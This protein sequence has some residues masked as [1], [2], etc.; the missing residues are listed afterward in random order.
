MASI[1]AAIA[2]DES[3]TGRVVEIKD[4]FAVGPI[5]DI[6]ETEGYQARRDWWKDVLTHSPY[7]DQIAIVDDKLTVNQLINALDHDENEF[8]WIW[9]GQNTHDVCGYYWLM[10]Q[11]KPY[12]GRLQVLYLNNLPFLNEKGQLFY[13]THLSEIQPKEFLKAK[14]LARPITLSEFELDPDEWK[15]LCQEN[16][17]VRFLEGGKKLVSMPI[18]FYDKEILSLLTKNAQKLPSALAHILSKMKVKTGDAFI[19]FRLKAIAEMGKIVFVGNWEKGW[20]DM[21]VQMPGG[22]SVVVED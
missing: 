17:G 20:K 9:M 5:V 4:D 10:S 21:V 19:V 6:Y 3:L 16:E 12:Q 15:K 11:L 7:E 22:S 14:R 8:I 18:S 13:P 2:L 1:E